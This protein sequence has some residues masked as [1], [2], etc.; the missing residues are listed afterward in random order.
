MAS[1]YSYSVSAYPYPVSAYRSPSP[2]YH[3][4][5]HGYY[6]HVDAMFQAAPMVYSDMSVAPPGITYSMTLPGYSTPWMIQQPASMQMQSGLAPNGRPLSPVKQF[7]Q[8]TIVSTIRPRPNTPAPSIIPKR[9]WL[10]DTLKQYIFKHK[11]ILF[12]DYPKYEI[13]KQDITDKFH[14]WVAELYPSDKYNITKDWTSS[15]FANSAF[16]PEYAARLDEFSSTAEFRIAIKESDFNKLA[17]DIV[18][19]VEQ[20]FKIQV[21]SNIVIDSNVKKIILCFYNKF[22]LEG[23]R[24]VFYVDTG[25]STTPNG[26]LITPTEMK[27][28]HDYIA[29]DGNVYSVLDIYQ[30]YMDNATHSRIGTDTSTDTSVDISITL[31]KIVNNIRKGVTIFMA[32]VEM[33]EC[34]EMI[35]ASRN[36]DKCEKQEKQSPVFDKFISPRVKLDF[37]IK[38]WNT[39]TSASSD[40]SASTSDTY[41]EVNDCSSSSECEYACP[42]CK[43]GIESGEIVCTTK[44][45]RRAMH[46]SCLLELYCHEDT[47]HAEFLCDKCIAKTK[48][49]RTDK[50]KD[51]YGRNTE[52][53]MGL[54]FTGF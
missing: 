19:N 35:L 24:I 27:Y 28:Q 2:A 10:L 21:E 54:L 52:M 44:C 13:Q 46:P 42:R 6:A 14:K 1:P 20:Y 26:I 38:I 47:A 36:K 17:Q 4:P 23:Q 30:N 48:D 34:S 22:I 18:S 3:V 12:G 16:L 51:K 25:S 41:S 49:K 53:L 50:R 32:Y 29:Y 11:G 9:E 15:V 45:C 7:V 31:F 40:D 5:S 8:P 39:T 37:Y 33:E 43:V